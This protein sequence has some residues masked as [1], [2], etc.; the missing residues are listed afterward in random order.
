M[1]ASCRSEASR[2]VCI[3][4]GPSL[5]QADVDACRGRAIVIA[6][7]YIYRMAP[8]ADYLYGADY[9]WWL[10]NDVNG[11]QAFP[12]RKLTPSRRVL[13]HFP[14]IE[15]LDR[16][17]RTGFDPTPGTV[18]TGGHGGYA[19]LHFA[20]Q[21]GATDVILLGYDL[22]PDASGRH[23]VHPEHP[24]GKHPCQE[25]KRQVYHSLIPTLNER[26]VTVRNCSR[27]TAITALPRADLHAV[28]ATWT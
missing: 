20:V 28:L 15:Y 1:S 14:E 23:H 3:G 17:G 22:Q 13:G 27:A 16:T 26:H 11:A 5:T 24:G 25:D 8:W 21:Q 9:L 12:G 2:W 19:A 10:R 4:A 18:R 7:N 6:I